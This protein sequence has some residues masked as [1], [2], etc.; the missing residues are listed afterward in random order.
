M[1]QLR[2][3][4]LLA[5]RHLLQQ[6]NQHL[7][8]V[9]VVVEGTVHLCVRVV[10]A[11]LDACAVLQLLHHVPLTHRHHDALYLFFTL[12]VYLF[13]QLGQDLSVLYNINHTSIRLLCVPSASR[14][15]NSTVF[16][17]ERRKSRSY[18]MFVITIGSQFS[19]ALT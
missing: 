17:L 6:E 5:A 1:L 10:G 11:E 2:F 13:P 15:L 19:P 16:R 8:T 14:K 18:F 7:V 12:L 4:G 9:A 3:V